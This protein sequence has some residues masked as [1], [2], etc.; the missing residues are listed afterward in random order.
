MTTLYFSHPAFLNH[1][2]GPGHPE[3]ADRL[4]ALEK[5][6]SDQAFAALI[7]REAPL[8]DLDKIRLL[9]DSRYIDALQAAAPHDGLIHLDPDTVMSP[10]TWEAALRAVGG[11]IAATD[12]VMKGEATNAFCATRP[13]GHH[14][15]A[16]RAYGFCLFNNVAIAAVHARLAYGIERAAVVDFDVHHGNGTQAMFWR[17]KNLFYASTHQMPLF[18]GTGSLLDTGE[19]NNIVN[20]PL[21]AGDSGV[22]FREAFETRIL[23]A[24]D[25][26]SPELL[27]IS[28]GFDAHRDDPL[29]GLLLNEEDFVWATAKLL[30]I[31]AKHAG[32]RVVSVLEGGYNLRG[33]AQ[34]A[35]AHIRVLM[36][37]SQSQKS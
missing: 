23:P 33:L 16:M 2:T 27:I 12:A 20:A 21:S 6:L 32:A 22:Q 31:A 3:R 1:D 36:G 5:A 10:G 11:A 30:D 24:L 7:R 37:T 13:P 4:R 25:R 19:Y 28:A 15:E 26:F 17:E 14:A 9:H 35:A 8:C 29:G 18:P 34:S